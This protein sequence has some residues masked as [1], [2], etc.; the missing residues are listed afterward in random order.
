MK[1]KNEWPKKHKTTLFFFVHDFFFLSWVFTT[2]TQKIIMKD[3]TFCCVCLAK[4][5]FIFCAFSPGSVTSNEC[6]DGSILIIIFF[7]KEKTNNPPQKN[8]ITKH[9]HTHTGN[10][11]SKNPKL[12]EKKK[13][14]KK[15]IGKRYDAACSDF[16]GLLGHTQCSH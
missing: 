8:R 1:E 13:L 5:Y 12:S 14:K 15:K 7:L 3:F 2:Q 6:W 11:S 16:L 10:S 4:N 9:T